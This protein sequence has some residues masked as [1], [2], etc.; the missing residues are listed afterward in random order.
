VAL[1]ALAAAVGLLAA[2]ADDPVPPPD[3]LVSGD[4]GAA[5]TLTY[6]TPLSVDSVYRQTIWEGTGDPLVEG[7]PV[8]LRYWVEDGRDAGVV[9]ENF[10]ASPVPR[11]LALDELGDDLYGTLSGQRVGARLL[12]VTPPGGT[13][14]TSYTAVTVLDVLPT[15]ATGTPVDPRADL[16]AVTLADGGAP[17]ITPTGTEPPSDLVVQALVRGTGAQVEADDVVTVQYVGFAW[18]TGAEFD[19][20]WARGVPQSFSLSD[21]PAWSEGL[22]EQTIGSQVMLVVPPSYGLGATSSQELAG[23]T[24]VFVIDIL[25]AN[26]EGVGR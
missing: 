11:V 26:P 10:S 9:T 8:L 6:V 23:Q 7:G 12:Q 25:A 20:T 15:R 1:A 19:S 21:V 4:P 17:T 5:P 22:A 3:I 16:P 14:E 13:V 24:L 2:C 18:T